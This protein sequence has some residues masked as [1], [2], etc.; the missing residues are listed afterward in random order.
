MT[1]NKKISALILTFLLLCSGCS[2]TSVLHTDA[3]TFTDDLDRTVRVVSYDRTAVLLGSFADVWMLAGG[4]VC[5]TADDAW[6]DFNLALSETTVNLGGTKN[7]SLEELLA[8]EPDFII[9]STNTQQNVSWKDTFDSAGIPAAYFDVSTFEDY[10]SMLKICTD[11]TGREDLYQLY[12]LNL[13]ET[14]DTTIASAEQRIAEEGPQTVLFLRA[15]A[16]SI[17]AKN[18]HGTVLGEMLADLGCINIADNDENLLENLSLESILQA[19]PDRIFIVQV[20]DDADAVKQHIQD[21]FAEN[22]AWYELDAV[23]EGN[24]HY[25]DKRLYNLK[26]NAYWGEAYEMLEAILAE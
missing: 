10:L 25:M 6:D 11:I 18:S 22:P 20:G 8:T 1:K 15:S 3:Y 26:P 4:T 17:R 7:L 21:M 16:A 5:A 9:A 23:K 19:N 14:I 24:V 2:N 13:Q 12:G